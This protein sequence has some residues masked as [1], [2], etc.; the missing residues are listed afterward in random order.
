M[1]WPSFFA[2]ILSH[3]A[4]HFHFAVDKTRT[5]TYTRNRAADNTLHPSFTSVAYS[6]RSRFGLAGL[7]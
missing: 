5:A 2:K 6:E 7:S 3:F 1:E 4:T